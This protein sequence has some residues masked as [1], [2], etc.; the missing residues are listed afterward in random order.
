MSGY[1]TQQVADLIGIKPNSIRHYVRRRLLRPARSPRGHYRFSFQDV[2]LLRTAKGMTDA[3]ISV[4]Q[5]NRALAKLQT[6]LKSVT[7]LS[8]VRI[9]AHGNAVVVREDDHV[10][11]VES[12]QMTI[13]FGIQALAADVAQ[14]ARDSAGGGK[15]PEQLDSDE[16]YN[17]GLDLEE[18]DP[19]QAPDAYKQAVR[20][21]PE[22][23]DAHVNLGRLYQSEGDIR[24]AKHHYETALAVRMDHELANYNLGT[25][26]DELEQREKA[27]DY[28][29]RAPAVP[30][31]HYNLARIRELQGDELNA[32]RH[33]R[34][35][36]RLVEL[37]MY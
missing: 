18:V 4:R 7:S 26:F 23:A 31:A 25:I 8:A 11:E 15:P 10:W 37:E 24:L 3:S 36:Q 28:Y 34:Q 35:Y 1:S 30:D 17:L 12:G 21:D 5:T 29:Q 20:L 27:A 22:N 2:V 33:L 16:W 19:D 14:L 32:K 13:D 6:D 9:Y